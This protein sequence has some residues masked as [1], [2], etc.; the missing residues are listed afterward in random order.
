L[1][2]STIAEPWKENQKEIKRRILKMLF[3]IT[4][5]KYIGKKENLSTYLL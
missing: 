5:T 3:A 4:P 2:S 1:L